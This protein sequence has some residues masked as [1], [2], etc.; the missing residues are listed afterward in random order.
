MLYGSQNITEY[1]ELY[2]HHWVN[3]FNHTIFSSHP[4]ETE[5]T[6][7]GYDATWLAALAL[8]GAEE[9]LKEK[10]PSI[11]LRNF[12]HSRSDAE[13]NS[14]I[15]SLIYSNALN[16][17]FH[18]ASVSITIIIMACFPVQFS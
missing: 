4:N 6:A 14:M 9:E 8:H 7:F 5:K 12:T 2:R 1:E 18:G 17:T 11:T 13:D 3:Y 16:T 15:R 10:N